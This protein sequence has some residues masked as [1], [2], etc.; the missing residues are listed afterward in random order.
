MKLRQVLLPVFRF[1]TT[2]F[3][4]TMSTLLVDD[5]DDDRYEG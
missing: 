1:V 2:K 3:M 4:L 5:W